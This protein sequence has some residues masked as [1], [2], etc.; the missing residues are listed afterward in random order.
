MNQSFGPWSTAINTGAKQELNTFWK[1]RLAMLPTLSRSRTRATWRALV[2]FGI[3]A[4][5][6]LAF[7]MLKRGSPAQNL[8]VVLD[9]AADAAEQ[10]NAGQPAS[11][12]ERPEKKEREAT[13]G[14]AGLAVEF[15]PRPTRDEEKIIAALQQ[16]TTLEFLDLPLEDGLTFLKEYHNVPIYFEKSAF[17]EAE[18]SLESNVTLK[19][20]GVRLESA[21][22]LILQPLLLDYLVEDDVLKITSKK[23]AQKKLITRT[24]PVADL[25]QESRRVDIEERQRKENTAE[26]PT[27]PG[28]PATSY[29][30]LIQTIT[31]TIDPDSWEELS[32][33][34]SSMAVQQAGSLVIRQTWSVHRKILQLLRD[35]REAKRLGQAALENGPRQPIN[36]MFPKL[37]RG[38]RFS[39][40]GIMDLDGDGE[41]SGRGCQDSEN[42]R[43]A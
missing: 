27:R 29:T 42:F 6:A 38:E 40:V 26:K 2:L 1:R 12:V 41:G 36:A 25:C 4:A 21:L 30:A 39:I 8:V 18:V 7:P 14:K 22:N 15:L 13:A 43:V 35:L 19:I 28:S 32:G 16:P 11:T 23:A 31:T 20:H 37:R 17:K 24:Y 3:V 34:G 10:D 5:A 33:V 9:S